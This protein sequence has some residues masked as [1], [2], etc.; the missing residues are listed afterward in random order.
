[1]HLTL[2]EVFKLTHFGRL[3]VVRGAGD[4]ASGVIQKLVRAGFAVCALEI[5]AP[6]SVRRSVSLSEAVFDG[7][8]KVE[9]IDAV[10]V[11]SAAEAKEIASTGIV[12]I[13]IDPEMKSIPELKPFAI[14]DAI[15]AKRNIGLSKD[16][17]PITIALG[18][19]FTAGIDC[20]VV[21]ETMR[22][23]DLGRL[24][25][26]G[27]AVANTGVPGPIEGVTKDRV[28]RSPVAG[29]L[30]TTR[31][32]GEQITKGEVV[33]DVE[34]EPFCAPIDGVLRG[35]MRDGS[36]VGK[37]FKIGDIDPRFEELAN[38]FT[39]SDKARNLGGAVLEAIFWLMRT[40]G[41]N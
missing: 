31:K 16:L 11:E 10:L 36:V 1:V 20:D 4:L 28:L 40:K 34:G 12:P 35:L 2:R 39:I 41:V 24:Y 26:S 33:G 22:G 15:V 14:V 30:H 37:G 18:P 9:D 32:I 7:N 38:C 13:L 6:L 19:G 29:V 25:F 27:S 8:A 5:F 23:H 17:A 21:I 3:I